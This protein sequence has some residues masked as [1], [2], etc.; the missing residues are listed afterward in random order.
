VSTN[1]GATGSGFVI[2]QVSG[3][4]VAAAGNE[5]DPPST[6]AD[7]L[8]DVNGYE[9]L[10]TLGKGGM[11]RVY[12][13]RQIALNRIV[14]LK[15]LKP[16]SGAF[17]DDLA[18]FRA[19][20]EAVAALQH[21][22][23]VQIYDVGKFRDAPY[24][25]LEYVDGGTLQQHVGGQPQ[26]PAFAAKIVHTLAVAVDAAHKHGIVHRDLKPSNVLLTRTGI[27]GSQK[28]PT[29]ALLCAPKATR[30]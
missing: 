26:S 29:L 2:E 20:A 4:P 6:G 5:T 21:P 14:A 1:P 28:S 9:V 11:G 25:S 16:G 13:A 24:F 8:P 17:T 27:P 23:I 22:N 3:S 12:K 30:V 18:R 7:L 15:M 19:E 10:A